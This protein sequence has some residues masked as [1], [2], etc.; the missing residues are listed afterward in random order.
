MTPPLRARLHWYLLDVAEFAVLTAMCEH[1]SDGSTIWAG[2]P[3]LAAYSK[4]S[5]RKV[6]YV[7]RD[8]CNR[9]IL[10]QLAPANSWN[11]RRPAIYRINEPG[12][13][14]DPRMTPYRT[15]QLWLPGICKTGAQCAPVPVHGLRLTGAQCAPDSRSKHNSSPIEIQHGDAALNLLP[16]FDAFKEQLR[17]ELPAEEWDLWVRP[18]KLER[19]LSVGN[20]QKHFLAALPPNTRIQSAALKRLP[21]MRELLGAA[22]LSISIKTYAHESEI[23]EAKERYGIDVIPKAWRRE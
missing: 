12:M 10:S 9:G 20:N 11:K 13:S 23:Q 1:C 2:I 22:G 16:T 8:L 7:L 14:E 4:L 5:E 15:D 3:R 6:Q 18:M 19:P 21:M 17:G